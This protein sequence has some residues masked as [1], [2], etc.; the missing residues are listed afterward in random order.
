MKDLV[1]IAQKSV[2]MD[3][4]NTFEL[5]IF[6]EGTNN[7]IKSIIDNDKSYS[8]DVYYALMILTHNFKMISNSDYLKNKN[9]YSYFEKKI[10][11]YYRTGG[12]RDVLPYMIKFN[13]LKE[14]G[15]NDSIRRSKQ[16]F[17]LLTFYRQHQGIPE[18][19]KHFCEV[20]DFYPEITD[21]LVKTIFTKR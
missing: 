18:E 19:L 21:D 8:Y 9:E 20:P 7:I 12:N 2:N 10:C 3:K 17:I 5:L 16:E 4:M 13:S 11:S 14:L 1:D 15:I 6:L